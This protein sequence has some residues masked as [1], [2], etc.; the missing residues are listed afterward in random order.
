[1]FW[2]ELYFLYT[3]A[4]QQGTHTKWS[5]HFLIQSVIWRWRKKIKNIP[6]S[7]M[8]EGT[9]CLKW[10]YKSDR[11]PQIVLFQ[12]SMGSNQIITRMDSHMLISFRHHSESSERL[13]GWELETA[14]NEL[15]LDSFWW[16]LSREEIHIFLPSLCHSRCV[17]ICFPAISRCYSETLMCLTSCGHKTLSK[18]VSSKALF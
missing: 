4:V 2:C 17:G 11:K 9:H 1:M 14:Q 18:I 12:T 15:W 10:A 3:T 16:T 6:C 13:C 7:F 8:Q 5:G